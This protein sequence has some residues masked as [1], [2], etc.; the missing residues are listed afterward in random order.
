LP[1]VIDI[2]RRTNIPPSKLLMPLAFAALMGGLTTLIGTPTNILISEALRAANLE[3]FG[4]FDYTPV[5]VFVLVAGIIFLVLIGRR[6]LPKRDIGRETAR[7]AQE[8]FKE[9]YELQESMVM[10]YLPDDSKLAGKTLG[11]SKLG[12]ILGLNVVA[13]IHNGQTQLAPG[14][15]TVLHPGDR[16][17]VEGRLDQLTEFHNRQHLVVED[18]KIP[19]E[20]LTSAESGAPTLR[21]SP[22][23]PMTSCCCKVIPLNSTPFAKRRTSSLRH[24]SQP[25]FTTWQKG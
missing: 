21:A 18:E 6:L 1:V 23:K 10:V 13:I 3:P 22:C 8:D 11:R 16:L 9:L 25:R 24:L 15:E 20:R 14:A 19:I 12:S 2:A 4:F 5:G 17:L 7:G